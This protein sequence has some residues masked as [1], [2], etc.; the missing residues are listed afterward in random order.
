[1]P[2][3]VTCSGVVTPFKLHCCLGHPSLSL[4][5]KLYPQFSSLS[6]LNCKSCQYVK[7]H[8]VH[9]SPRVNNCASAPFE[10]VNSDVWGPCPVVSPTGFRYF[11]TFVD[12]YSQT[13][14]LYLMKNHL[15]LFSH[16]RAFCTEIHTQFHVYVQN[17][18][19]DNAKE[20]MSEQFQIFMLQNDILH[21]TMGEIGRVCCPQKS[22]YDLKQSL[23]AWF[24]KFNEVIENFGMQKSKSDYS[25]FYRNSQASIILLVVYVDDI[26][27][28]GDYVAGISSLE[29]FLHGQ[30]HTVKKYKKMMFFLLKW[31]QRTIQVLPTYTHQGDIKRK[32]IKYKKKRKYCIRKEGNQNI[33]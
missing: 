8:R 6:S 25:V 30:F 26:I 32:Q 19:S 11:V 28:I 24:G 29:S 4:L 5:K 17:L 14:W 7:L 31:M 9:L 20:Y 12:D 15:E 22:L 16:F 21:Q 10:L 27:I 3:S 1:M 23:R 13:N 33:L 2:K 18:R